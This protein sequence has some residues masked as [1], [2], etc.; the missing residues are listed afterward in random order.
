MAG[1]KRLSTI[2]NTALDITQ[3]GPCLKPQTSSPDSLPTETEFSPQGE[4][5]SAGT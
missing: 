1:W 2:L 5:A 4:A 3:A